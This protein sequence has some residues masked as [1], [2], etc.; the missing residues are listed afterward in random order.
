MRKNIYFLIVITLIHFISFS[1]EVISGKSS[2]KRFSLEPNYER[3]LPPNLF[4]D[5]NSK[6]KMEMEF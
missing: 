1:Q 2:A 5:L 4:V 3:E 6:M